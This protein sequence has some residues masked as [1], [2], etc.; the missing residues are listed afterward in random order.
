MV[1]TIKEFRRYL[2]NQTVQIETSR[3]SKEKR[4]FNEN[5][6]VENIP[7]KADRVTSGTGRFEMR[8]VTYFLSRTIGLIL[9]L[10]VTVTSYE[11]RTGPGLRVRNGS[12]L[13]TGV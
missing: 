6:L 9:T 3:R 4:H 7:R 8:L 1:K 10:A 2:M 12:G 5:G 13:E 11:F